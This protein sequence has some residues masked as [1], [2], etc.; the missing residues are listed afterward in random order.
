MRLLRLDPQD[1][2]AG[3]PR[4][5]PQLH[6]GRCVDPVLRV[7]K[8][9]AR[10]LDRLHHAVHFLLRVLQHR[11]L[12]HRPADGLVLFRLRPPEVPGQRLLAK[13]VLARLRRL[14]DEGRVEIIRHGQIDRIDLRLLQQLL[15]AAEGL[16]NPVF[17]GELRRHFP[18]NPADSDHLTMLRRELPVALD[19]QI[20]REA[21]ADQADPNWVH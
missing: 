18:G 7:A 9:D 19:V 14:D 11:A 1:R 10:R 6:E 8:R 20:C 2:P 15:H 21:A 3:G 13:D 4:Q 5:P 16:G 17:C 12:G